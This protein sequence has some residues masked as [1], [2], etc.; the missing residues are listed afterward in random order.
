MKL[1][2]KER[3]DRWRAAN[4]GRESVL[5]AKWRANNKDKIAKRNAAYWAAVSTNPDVKKAAVERASAWQKAN[6][7]RRAAIRSAYRARKRQAMGSHTAQDIIGLHQKQK[8]RCAVCLTNLA[9]SYHVDHII[10]LRRGGGND[11]SNLQLLCVSCNCSKGA[12]DP[13]KFAQSRG[14]LL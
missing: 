9:V 8:G 10:P 4:P 7:E 12:R 2:N 1:T 5:Q 14:M 11:K 6:K 3:Q 13:F